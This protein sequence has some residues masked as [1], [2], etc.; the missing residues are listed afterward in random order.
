MRIQFKINLLLL[1]VL[2]ALAAVLGFYSVMD[3]R[4]SLT[5]EHAGYMNLVIDHYVEDFLEPM[6][7]SRNAGDRLKAAAVAHRFSDQTRGDMLLFRTDGTPVDPEDTN[8]HP[9]GASA[10]PRSPGK[11]SS[12]SRLAASLPSKSGAASP[13]RHNPAVSEFFVYRTY[14]PWSWRVI[15]AVPDTELSAGLFRAVARAFAVWAVSLIAAYLLSLFLMRRSFVR[16]IRR[17]HALAFDIS[18]GGSPPPA[19]STRRD[20]L[21]ELS[22]SLE[23]MGIEIHRTQSALVAANRRLEEEVDRRTRTLVET[24]ATLRREIEERRSTETR[25]SRSLAERE[26]LLREVHHRVKNNLLV[27]YALLEFE[28]QFHSDADPALRFTDIQTRIGS[29]AAIHQS[30]YAADDLT[31]VNMK[32]YLNELVSRLSVTLGGDNGRFSLTVEADGVALCLDRAVPCGL[33]V[34]ELVTNSARHAFPE[35]RRGTVSV[36]LCRTADGGCELTVRDDGIGPEQHAS[37]PGGIGRCLVSALVDQLE[38]E[39]SWDHGAGTTCR[40]TFAIG[41]TKRHLV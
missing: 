34:N 19:G 41:N 20:E 3:L 12:W 38:G 31:S 32:N 22:R 36:R 23:E 37:H 11:V 27:I 13:L 2:S 1:F 15:F 9:T 26:V 25:L 21:G 10:R 5:R 17:L 28:K 30:L 4:G 16:P 18:H 14:A 24:N 35:G 6:G 7:A 8:A 39:I 29:I 33:I 40:V